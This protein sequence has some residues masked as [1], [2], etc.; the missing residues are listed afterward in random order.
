MSNNTV[1]MGKKEIER[2]LSMLGEIACRKNMLVDLA[3][4]GGSALSVAFDIREATRDVDA[5]F[6]KEKTFIREAS[7]EVAEK[8]G[9]DEDWINDAVKPYLSAL[10]EDETVLFKSYPSES[11]VGL[12]VFIP[13]PD[14]MLAMKCIDI[15]TSPTDKD[16]DDVKNL[17][18]V[19]SIKS[20][21]EALDV[22]NSF[23]PAKLIQPKTM[24]ALEEI[25]DE[26]NAKGYKN[27]NNINTLDDDYKSSL[28]KHVTFKKIENI[29]DDDLA[30]YLNS[31]RNERSKVKPK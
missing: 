21:D 2:A 20:V 1:D 13:T 25:F 16:I 15:R 27:P 4:Y 8:M 5:V 6:E 24:F 10:N 23:Y 7:I 3:V 19:C 18:S 17:I 11:N 26:V 29:S 9:L 22:V 12:R 28:L 31:A 14:Y 30:S